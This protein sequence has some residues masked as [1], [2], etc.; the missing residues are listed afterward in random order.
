[1]PPTYTYSTSPHEPAP[2]S[3]PAR[4]RS[5]ITSALAGPTTYL[6][7]NPTQTRKLATKYAVPLAS[8]GLASP[9]LSLLPLGPLGPLL[10][11]LATAFA[12]FKVRQNCAGSY[13]A[14]LHAAGLAGVRGQV[15]ALLSFMSLG[16]VFGAPGAAAQSWFSTLVVSSGGFQAPL[17][18][19]ALSVFTNV[20]GGFGV[21]PGIL[22]G[23][24]ANAL[25]RE[26][27]SI[28]VFS[29]LRWSLDRTLEL[30]QRFVKSLWGVTMLKFVGGG[31]E[32]GP[33]N[34]NE[35]K[36]SWKSR[37]ATTLV[38]K[39]GWRNPVASR[40]PQENLKPEERLNEWEMVGGDYVKRE[41]TKP[42]LPGAFPD[43]T[44]NLGDDWM[45]FD[46][47]DIEG[48]FIFDLDNH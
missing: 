5:A 28:A 8:A 23:S 1:M 29:G 25:I 17:V 13:Y 46:D 44:Y 27:E 3:L 43:S 36:E 24:S 33:E 7:S 16:A 47:Q 20:L 11:L 48:S 10:G 37:L 15:C 21:L 45:Q 2:S 19:L 42:Q 12:R 22:G 6:F 4:T 35:T 40:S 9:L 41:E 14:L 34:M 31:E 32:K 26:L 30:W 39:V 18:G 38:E